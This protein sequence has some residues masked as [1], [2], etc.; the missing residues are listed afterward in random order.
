MYYSLCL[1]TQYWVQ[2]LLIGFDWITVIVFL[3]LYWL[4][5]DTV[6]Q[7]I[8]GT[9]MK[10]IQIIERK[11][12][13]DYRS[14]N[15]RKPSTNH[16][17]QERRCQPKWE[18]DQM[19]LADLLAPLYHT[20]RLPQCQTELSLSSCCYLSSPPLSARL[21]W[22]LQD[23]TMLYTCILLTGSLIQTNSESNSFS[24]AQ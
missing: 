6:G 18:E 13:L 20:M 8:G 23:T 22:Y 11:N 12:L 17:R 21:G 15:K 14:R 3:F 4:V 5:I 19:L 2:I 24:M 9:R 1:C 7:S 10:N 16:C